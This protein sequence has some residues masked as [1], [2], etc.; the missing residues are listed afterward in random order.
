MNIYVNIFAS[1][2]PAQDG[3]C[4][5]I[6]HDVVLYSLRGGNAGMSPPPQNRK[7]FW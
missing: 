7:E 4:K 6:R 3:L 1:I 2:F 5:S